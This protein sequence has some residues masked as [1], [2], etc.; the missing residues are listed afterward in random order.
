M[1]GLELYYNIEG[2]SSYEKQLIMMQACKE[3]F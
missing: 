1:K 3:V 2:S